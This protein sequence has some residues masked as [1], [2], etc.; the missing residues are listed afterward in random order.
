MIVREAS[1]SIK[2]MYLWVVRCRVYLCAFSYRCA[3]R[4]RTYSRQ[5]FF[6]QQAFEVALAPTDFGRS[7][8]EPSLFVRMTALKTDVD[9]CRPVRL[10]VVRQLDSA[11]TAKTRA[12]GGDGGRPTSSV[13]PHSFRI[14]PGSS[15][16]PL[17]SVLSS[18][19]P[20]NRVLCFVT[21]STKGHMRLTNV[22]TTH[23]R[24]WNTPRPRFSG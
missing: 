2:I 9:E 3:C 1:N 15:S 18:G 12:G 4:S 6:A 13:P 20:A 23:G 16:P 8:C 24:F 14:C 21:G 19:P 7:K 5:L 22:L 10:V 11:Q 17:K